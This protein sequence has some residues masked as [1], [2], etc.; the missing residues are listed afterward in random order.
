MAKCKGS[1]LRM[2]LYKCP[3]CGA[4]LQVF[5]DEDII[6][7]WS[8]GEIINREETPACIEWCV[9]ARS[10]LGERKRKASMK[11]NIKDS[12]LSSNKIKEGKMESTNAAKYECTVCGYVYNPEL[13]DP[14]SGIEPGTAFKD[15]P[16]DWVCPVC[17]VGKDLFEIIKE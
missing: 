8:C 11:D 3:G 14:D 12:S 15:I 13:G 4:E 16:D 5:S 6:K 10:C 2:A 7:C 17:G 1:K 9:S